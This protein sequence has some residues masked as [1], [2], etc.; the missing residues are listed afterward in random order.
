MTPHGTDP[1]QWLGLPRRRRDWWLAP[2]LER[3]CSAALGRGVQLS[4]HFPF[5]PRVF[6]RSTLSETRETAAKTCI[7][8]VAQ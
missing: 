4:F 5:S 7:G 1:P 3:R 2:L 8:R 6:H